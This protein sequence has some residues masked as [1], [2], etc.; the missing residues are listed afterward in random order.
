MNWKVSSS[1]GHDEKQFVHQRKCS[2]VKYILCWKLS[3]QCCPLRQRKGCWSSPDLHLWWK[4][5][6]RGDRGRGGGVGEEV[7]EGGGDQSACHRWMDSPGMGGK[8]VNGDRDG[9][10]RE[11]CYE[12]LRLLHSG[13]KWLEW[14]WSILKSFVWWNLNNK[15][16][17][18]QCIWFAERKLCGG[19]LFSDQI[20]IAWSL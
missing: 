6:E 20:R 12:K 11:Y 19:L 1:K 2:S 4:W 5:E 3:I 14:S 13:Q 16:E 9:L 17:S 7:E 8:G 18:L 15:D 10:D